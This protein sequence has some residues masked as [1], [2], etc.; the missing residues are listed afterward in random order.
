MDLL[1][2]VLNRANLSAAQRKVVKNGGA[3]GI[4]GM[5]VSELEHFMNQY[6]EELIRAIETGTYMPQ[7]VLGVEI[8][9]PSGGV[10]LLGIPVVIDRVIQQAIHQVLSH[11]V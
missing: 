1:K 11:N 9:K 2:K 6:R 3:A 10:R 4:D 8:P 7:S 5:Q